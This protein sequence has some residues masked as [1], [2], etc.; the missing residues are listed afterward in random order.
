MKPAFYCS[1]YSLVAIFLCGLAMSVQCCHHLSAS[2]TLPSL[3][4]FVD[5][6][7]FYVSVK[8]TVCSIDA[9]AL[10]DFSVLGKC[11]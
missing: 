3:M 10:S 6:Y 2:S 9:A 1:I 5:Y 7:T 11:I 8:S 4:Y